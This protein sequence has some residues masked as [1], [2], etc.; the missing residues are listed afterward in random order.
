MNPNNI[1]ELIPTNIDK[2]FVETLIQQGDMKIERIVSTG[3]SSPEFGWY[4]QPLAE[5]VMVLSGE[6]II[7]FED[8]EDCHL[9][10]GSYLNIPAHTKHKVKWTSP[11]VETVWLAV[12]YPTN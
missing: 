3:Q 9:V 8:G 2:E 11:M 5:W 1:F 10:A 7:V 6:A 12:H 4:D